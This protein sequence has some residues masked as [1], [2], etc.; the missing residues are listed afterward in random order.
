VQRIQAL[1]MDFSFSFSMNLTEMGAAMK[2]AAY[3]ENS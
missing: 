3:E 1:N 2:P